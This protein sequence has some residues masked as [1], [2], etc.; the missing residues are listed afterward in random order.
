MLG[1]RRFRWSFWGGWRKL[2]LGSWRLRSRS[3]DLGFFICKI[4]VECLCLCIF[5]LWYFLDVLLFNLNE[6]W[7]WELKYYWFHLSQNKPNKKY[8][9][10]PTIQNHQNTVK[11]KLY[12]KIN[13]IIHIHRIFYN[14]IFLILKNKTKLKKQMLIK[15]STRKQI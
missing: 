15:T 2:R 1:L 3:F 10:N 9:N 14:S 5:I 7:T 11:N 13:Q 8:N 6:G 4:F 12:P